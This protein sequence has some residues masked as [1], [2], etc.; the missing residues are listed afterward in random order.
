LRGSQVEIA[1]GRAILRG[2]FR[3]FQAALATTFI[4]KVALN[5]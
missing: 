4:S 1:E 5:T 2:T 3:D